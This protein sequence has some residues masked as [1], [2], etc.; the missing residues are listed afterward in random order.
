M[1]P[2]VK[3]PVVEDPVVEEVEAI[4]GWCGLCHFF[5]EFPHECP[6]KDCSAEEEGR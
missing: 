2:V 4:Y 1:A 6:G 5:V 3:D